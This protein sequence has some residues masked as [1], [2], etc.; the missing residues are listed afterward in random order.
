VIDNDLLLGADVVSFGG[1]G[2][3]LVAHPTGQDLWLLQIV[4]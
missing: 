4:L 2:A 1:G 3:S